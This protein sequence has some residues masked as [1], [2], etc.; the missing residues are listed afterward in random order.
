[1]ALFLALGKPSS[2]VHSRGNAQ[3]PEGCHAGIS[4]F[5]ASML[6]AGLASTLPTTQ[7]RDSPAKSHWTSSK[8][9][10]LKRS[11]KSNDT[12]ARPVGRGPTA[13]LAFYLGS[14]E[15]QAKFEEAMDL[16]ASKQA[17]HWTTGSD[18]PN[19]QKIHQ[20]ECL[21]RINICGWYLMVLD[22]SDIGHGYLHL[23]FCYW[24]WRSIIF[25]SGHGLKSIGAL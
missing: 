21:Y 12:R 23:D 5:I 7:V 19:H 25:G 1:M 13:T 18:S 3:E 22:I 9:V 16:F 24:R 8:P 6:K 20:N 10:T 14:L 15:R 4:T 17:G 11:K 2:R